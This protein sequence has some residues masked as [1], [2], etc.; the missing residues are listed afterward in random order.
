MK[1]IFFWG[2]MPLGLVDVH[3]RFAGKYC[4][5]LQGRNVSQEINKKQEAIKYPSL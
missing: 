2:V 5:H 1:Y 4:L 3:R